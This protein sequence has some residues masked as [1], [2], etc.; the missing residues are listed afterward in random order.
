MRLRATQ[1][2]LLHAP[3]GT[4]IG[5][6]CFMRTAGQAR[7]EL[8][9]SFSGFVVHDPAAE[10][11]RRI[12]ALASGA[13]WLAG[14]VYG[15]CL[16][17]VRS[18][19]QASGS[20]WTVAFDAAAYRPAVAG[21]C[22][23]LPRGIT[24]L[25]QPLIDGLKR[26]LILRREAR[27]LGS[28]A[29][30]EDESAGSRRSRRSW[31]IV[32]L[33]RLPFGK[34]RSLDLRSGF[35]AV[36]R[37]TLRRAVMEPQ[38][39]LALAATVVAI[40]FAS[41]ISLPAVG[42][43]TLAASPASAPT[44]AETP[45][46]TQV[47][48]PIE[49]FVLESPELDRAEARYASRHNRAGHREDSLGWGNLGTSGPGAAKAHAVVTIGR[50]EDAASSS[51]LVHTARRAALDGIAVVRSARPQPMQTK[52]GEFEVA[53]MAFSVVDG[54]ESACMAFRH[55]REGTDVWISGWLCNGRKVVDRPGLAC[56]LDRLSLMKAGEDKVLRAVFTEAERRRVM[57]PTSRLSTG[58]RP[59][60]LDAD[61]R[62]PAIREALAPV[63]GR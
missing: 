23:S 61:G 36:V 53:D 19:R 56:M 11:R 15:T 42:Q 33:P 21:L 14:T 20:R 55:V 35:A 9:G 12:V 27:S 7:A 24:A 40:G 29:P 39:L 5:T 48:R 60:W 1:A 34:L 41:Q 47:R 32:R 16:A 31:T 3:V 44:A 30:R 49:L 57:C 10:R 50:S 63:R 26:R 8:L 25:L 2:G 45:G 46:W 18:I 37:A 52:F 17:A 54:A 38:P 58:R 28:A 43:T 4:G 59:H 13:G 6:G 51:L 62:P 22:R